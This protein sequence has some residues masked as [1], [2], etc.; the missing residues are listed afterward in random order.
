VSQFI[1]R[2]A[3]IDAKG[4]P[5]GRGLLL[6][7]WAVAWL[8][9]LVP[10]SVVALWTGGTGPGALAATAALLLL[11]GAAAVYAALHPHRGLH[12]R[13]ADTWVVRR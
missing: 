10:L 3:V 2:L 11:G 1:F 5:A 12:D 4:E 7:R 13:L 8:P 9:L 6:K